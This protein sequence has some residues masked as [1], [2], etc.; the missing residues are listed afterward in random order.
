MLGT[1]RSTH[2]QQTQGVPLPD[3]IPQDAATTGTGEPSTS[4]APLATDSL[5][6]PFQETTALDQT[7]GA[8]AVVSASQAPR[9]SIASEFFAFKEGLRRLVLNVERFEKRLVEENLIS[10]V[11]AAA[12]HTEKQDSGLQGQAQPLRRHDPH[13]LRNARKSRAGRRGP[14]PFIRH[15]WDLVVFDSVPQEPLGPPNA[16]ELKDGT[17]KC[18]QANGATGTGYLETCILRPLVDGSDTILQVRGQRLAEYANYSIIDMV[19]GEAK[20]TQIVILVNRWDNQSTRLMIESLQKFIEISEVRVD[21]HFVRILEDA[22][23]LKNTFDKPSVIITTPE[24]Y[25]SLI[26]QQVI[27]IRDVCILLVYEAEYVFR[28]AR[29]EGR[30]AATLDRLS[31]CQV[32]LACH[33]G[34]KEIEKASEAFDFDDRKAVFS[35]DHMNLTSANH[36]CFADESLTESLLLRAIALSENHAVVVICRD[37]TE[38][39]H[40]KDTLEKKAKVLTVVSLAESSEAV[41]GLLVTPQISSRALQNKGHTSVRMILNLSGMSLN[42]DMY[43]EMLASYMDVGQNC[44]IITRIANDL[45]LK[46]LDPLGLKFTEISSNTAD[47]PV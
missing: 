46:G 23:D 7:S 6:K 10:N 14:P 44:D 20:E 17:L 27:R 30:I 35:L 34:T 8:A 21:V 16:L 15:Q 36:F 4:G 29:T 9:K 37:V 12:P 31:I 26:D 39:A 25:P 1:E 18:L 2:L 38:T 47:L 5:P 42:P 3:Q 40:L 28:N 11:N 33:V 22:A 45:T 19:D 41:R 24:I 43:L 32:I 13:F